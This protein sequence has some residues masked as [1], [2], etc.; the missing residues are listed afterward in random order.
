MSSARYRCRTGHA[1]SPESL[2]AEQVERVDHALWAALR[3]LEEGADFARRMARRMQDKDLPTA[4]Q[5]YVER[6]AEAER[7]ASVLRT[8]LAGS[9]D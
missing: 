6:A 2:A 5:R 3:S 9:T 1:Y 7:N 8:L 4:V